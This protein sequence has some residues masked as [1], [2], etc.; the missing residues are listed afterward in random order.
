MSAGFGLVSR[1]AFEFVKLE[2]YGSCMFYGSHKLVSKSGVVAVYFFGHRV[3]GRRP[4]GVAIPVRW[5][6][7]RPVISGPRRVS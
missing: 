7:E 6:L 1:C 2:V 5:G 4:P 3:V